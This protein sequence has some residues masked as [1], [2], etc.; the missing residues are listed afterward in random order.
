MMTSAFFS[1]KTFFT[2]EA[3][4]SVS[5]TIAKSVK[6]EGVGYSAVAVF[7]HHRD[8]K[9]ALDELNCAGFSHDD[10]ALVA[11]QAQRCQGYSGLIC[12]SSFDDCQLGLESAARQFCV[13][14]L[15]EG[16]YLLL[17]NGSKYDLDAVSKIVS[18]RHHRVEVWRF[19]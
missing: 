1:P 18:R 2:S 4:L 17:V 19:K 8:V 12:R 16:K 11:R 14:L 7:S 15:S 10:L 9:V 6:Q 5:N 3:R 13:K